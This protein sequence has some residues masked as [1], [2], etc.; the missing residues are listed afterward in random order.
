MSI[1]NIPSEYKFNK[2]LQL[3]AENTK[4]K[5]RFAIK[6]L[7]F[8]TLDNQEGKIIDISGSGMLLH[9][10]C[11]LK[12]GDKLNC[13]IVFVDGTYMV[14]QSKV[15]RTKCRHYYGVKFDKLNDHITDY[16]EGSKG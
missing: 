13:R 6:G 1:F 11:K 9:T 2:R 5:V 12:I 4:G 3:R 8:N 10:L 15:V 16:L 7:L 14:V